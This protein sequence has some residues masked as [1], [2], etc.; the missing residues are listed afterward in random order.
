MDDP[1]FVDLIR[2]VYGND[3]KA[4]GHTWR[5]WKSGVR[6]QVP[7]AYTAGYRLR[8]VFNEFRLAYVWV[9]PYVSKVPQ[10]TRRIATRVQMAGYG[11]IYSESAIAIRNAGWGMGEAFGGPH[12]A[13]MTD[14]RAG[15][16]GNVIGYILSW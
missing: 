15:E 9:E 14:T 12:I 8:S 6:I 13:G 7:R 4:A 3:F 5:Y 2:D 11:A 1:R 16:V 10:Y